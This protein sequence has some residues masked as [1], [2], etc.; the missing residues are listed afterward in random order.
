MHLGEERER[1]FE[2]KL[3]CLL[4]LKYIP[5]CKALFKQHSAILLSHCNPVVTNRT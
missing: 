5:V 4:S 1:M 3:I 2:Y